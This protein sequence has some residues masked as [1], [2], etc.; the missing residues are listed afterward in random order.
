MSIDENAL[1]DQGAYPSIARKL[2]NG[3]TTRAHQVDALLNHI[4]T[5]PHPVVVCGDLNDLPVQLHRISRFETNWP[6]LLR[7]R[8]AA[9]GSVI[10]E[11]CFFC[12]LTTS[13]L[14]KP[15]RPTAFTTY[16]EVNFSDH[17]RGKG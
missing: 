15:C 3:F 17:F 13:S 6:A 4:Q 10:T 1:S 11:S 7:R 2:K 5:S 12:A 16:R 8:G 9:L 14:V